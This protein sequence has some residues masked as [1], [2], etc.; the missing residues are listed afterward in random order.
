VL[1][2][3]EGWN[4]RFA[5]EGRSYTADRDYPTTRWVNVTPSYF[6]TFGLEAVEGRTLT[7][8]DIGGALPVAVVTRNW[9]RRFFPG[10]SPLGR[11]VRLGDSR[12]ERPWRTIVG[13]VPDVWY[14]GS[15]DETPEVM[16]TPIA[17]GDFSFLSVAIAATGNPMAIAEV[18]RNELAAI[19]PDQPA[20]F[21]RT[22]KEA[23]D[24]N[25]WFYGVFG[26]LFMVFGFAALF[27]A[28]IGVY[29][30]MAFSVSRRTQEV[31]VRMALGAAA[32][33]VLRLFLRQGAV[34]LAIGVALGL[35]LAVA[36]SNGIKFVMFQVDITNPLMFAGVTAMLL[37][38][39]FVATLLPARRATR[40]DPMVAL[41]Y[42]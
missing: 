38:T 37:V 17:Q 31:G 6:P 16:F 22:L 34:Q 30:V 42:E 33:D 26:T 36:L 25:T 28:T 27:L 10:D 18:V 5:I 21:V 4:N 8:A 2:G 3:L 1:P 20:Y 24:Q 23:I 13:V 19:D 12:S 11:R 32:G 15:D 40:V 29:G 41:R 14:Q 9:A 7:S 35:G 39:G